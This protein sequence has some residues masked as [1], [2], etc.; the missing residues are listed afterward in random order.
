MKGVRIV[1]LLAVWLCAGLAVDV[2][3]APDAWARS[4]KLAFSEPKIPH[5][6]RPRIP[7]LRKPRATYRSVTVRRADGTVL[8]G[9]RDALGT[10]L[11]GPD[12]KSVTCKRGSGGADIN[13]AC[14]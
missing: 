10:H 7:R 9:H 8:H 6:R 13:I 11:T 12:G 2:G 3:A 1:L 5:A 4:R 14:R